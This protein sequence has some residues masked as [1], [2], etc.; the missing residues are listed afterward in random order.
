MLNNEI[1][2]ELASHLCDVYVIK[3]HF[4]KESRLHVHVYF[5]YKQKQQVIQPLVYLTNY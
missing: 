4:V 1:L 2:R 3:K 5:F